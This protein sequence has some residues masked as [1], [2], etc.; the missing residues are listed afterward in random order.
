MRAPVC[1]CG[2]GDCA[3]CRPGSGPRPECKHCGATLLATCSGPTCPTRRCPG[4]DVDVEGDDGDAAELPWE[5]T[6]SEGDAVAANDRELDAFI[7]ARGRRD[8]GHQLRR[9]R[10][11]ALGTVMARGR[12]AS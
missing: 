10:L 1:L 8:V 6:W 5:R 11:H 2:A 4:P 7:A 12:C 3:A 9:D